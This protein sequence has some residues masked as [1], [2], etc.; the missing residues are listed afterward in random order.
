LAISS[1]PLTEEALILEREALA[2]KVSL[3]V[4]VRGDL[5]GVS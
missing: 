4:D 2:A 3:K 5:L 1:G